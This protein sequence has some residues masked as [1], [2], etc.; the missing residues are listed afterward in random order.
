MMASRRRAL[1]P[2][3]GLLSAA[4]LL[5]EVALTRLLSTLYYPPYVFVVLSLAVLGIGLGAAA[6]TAHNSLRHRRHAGRYP[7]AAALSIL[8]LVLFVAWGASLDLRP[9]LFLL[10][11]LP[12]IFVG[13]TL[14]LLF[15]ASSQAS[16]QLYLADLAGA[17]LGALLAVPALDLL[18]GTDALLVAA[19]FMALSALVLAP[20][21]S[22]RPPLALLALSAIIFGAN[23]AGH[24]LQ[25]DMARL[26]SDKPIVDTL[27]RGQLLDTRWDAFARTDLVS[28]DDGGPYRLYIDGAAGSIMPPAEDNEFLLR[29]IGLFPFATQ[30]PRTV[31]VIGPGGGLDVWFGLRSG[32]EEIVAVEVNRASVE[33]VEAYA[34]YNGD[35]YGQE[36][37]RIVYDE[38]RS[39]LRREER[40]YD[41]IFMS[42][43]V[44]LAA[45]RSGYALVEESTYTVEAFHDYLDHLTPEGQVALKLYDEATLTRALSTALAVLRD[46]GLSDS[47]ALQHVVALLD[48][49]SDSPIPLLIVRNTPYTAEESLALGSVARRIGFVPLF[50]PQV[51]AQPP[52]DA[53]E[54]G[55]RPFSDIVADAES[56]ISP[57]S[58]DRPFFYQFERGIPD[59][60]R[61]LLIGLAV[62][63]VAGAALLIPLQRRATTS[64]WR[65]SPVYFG[66][67]GLG[68]MALEVGFIQ[69]SRL[70]LGHPTLTVT[71]VL[72]TLLVVGGLGSGAAGRLLPPADRPPAWPI[73]VVA[74][75]AVAW[76]LIWPSVSHRFLAAE[77]GVRVAV[78]VASLAPIALFMGMPFPLALRHVGRAGRQAVALAWA[79]N[80]VTTVAG[81]VLA[82]AVAIV[83]GFSRV[84]LAGILAYAV[85]AAVLLLPALLNLLQGDTHRPLQAV[86]QALDPRD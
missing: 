69:Q 85:A 57:T 77:R 36:S 39:V 73:L 8:L 21:G 64:F 80:G 71:A 74:V 33:L 86:S 24:F 1:M 42:Q 28:P 54:A 26:P 63:V 49:R 83:A 18:G 3:L 76:I 53:V 32:A 65:W 56:D 55:D 15:S 47:E 79:V 30:E 29:D 48:P 22:R 81:S 67:L 62:L 51:L 5:L 40:R 12:F 61:P 7:A 84:L 9:L 19:I 45:E 50:L 68:F 4:A 82:I 2:A 13:L 75:L 17:G 6:A 38:G 10:V 14:A 58:D 52:L 35:L 46:R 37:V 16:P 72:A 23:V 44:T 43:V 11:T 66:A 41:L 31:F 60:L 59:N 27:Q 34:D 20:A 25:I 78:V 70:F